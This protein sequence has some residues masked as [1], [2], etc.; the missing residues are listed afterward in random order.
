MDPEKEAYL[1]DIYYNPKHPASFSGLDK[2]YREIR[3]E[4]LIFR[5]GGVT[6]KLTTGQSLQTKLFKN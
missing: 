2:L 3:R 4:R 5:D 6:D 1:K